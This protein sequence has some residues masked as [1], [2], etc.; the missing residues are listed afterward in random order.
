[1][2]EHKQF[3]AIG[4]RGT[5]HH[6]E[7]TDRRPASAIRAITTVK[8]TEEAPIDTLLQVDCGERDAYCK[9]FDKT[10]QI[11]RVGVNN[12]TSC[13]SCESDGT[14]D[15]D[16]IARIAACRNISMGMRY[17]EELIDRINVN[18][19]E[20]L[21]PK[22]HAGTILKD[23]LST[24]LVYEDLDQHD[25]VGFYDTHESQGKDMSTIEQLKR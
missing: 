18:W 6:D 25:T 19:D 15:Y 1:L 17:D 13:G 5:P 12:T 11:T 24:E 8:D 22:S 9:A 14:L 23:T 16:P 2:R 4:P 20:E 3:V 21:L 7:C 10:W